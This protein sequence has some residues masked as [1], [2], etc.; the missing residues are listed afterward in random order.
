MKIGD[1][2]KTL[3][4][5]LFRM[6]IV[7]VASVALVLSQIDK[8]LKSEYGLNNIYILIFFCSFITLLFTL[9]VEFYC[10]YGRREKKKKANNTVYLKETIM[11]KP[12]AK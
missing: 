7:G 5:S 2:M 1:N 10:L 11:K 4:I 6:V 3:L 8:Y 9:T 12:L